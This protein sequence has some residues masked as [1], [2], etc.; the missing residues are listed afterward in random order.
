MGTQNDRV[1][2]LTE[3]LRRNI[4]VQ[5]NSIFGKTFFSK[6]LDTISLKELA[7]KLEVETAFL[8]RYAV[9]YRENLSKPI[10]ID[11]D[12][13]LQLFSIYNTIEGD[14][15][16]LPV[17]E[18]NVSAIRGYGRSGILRNPRLPIRESNHLV[19]LIVHMIGDG[20]LTEEYGT[21][22]CPQYSNRNAFLRNQF[23]YTISEVFGDVSNCIRCYI[24]RSNE[25][26]SYIAFSKWIGYLLRY[27]YPDARFDE[28]SGSLPSAFFT[29][30][31]ELK[32]EIVRTFGDDDGHVGAHGI[33]FTSGG[34]TI[35]EQMRELIVEL[36]EVTLAPDECAQL[37]VS[38]GEVKAVRSY[39]ILDV[40]RPM[41]AW[42][43]EYI[44]F[45]H[46]DR[47]ERL[48]FQ[49][50]CDRVWVERGLDGFDLDFLTLMELRAGG[51]VEEIARRFMV[52]EDF[53]FKVVQ[54]LREWKWIRRVEKRQYTTW[55]Q[56][57]S[58][59][60]AF[61]ERIWSR[62]WS[63]GDRVVMA[64]GWWS[65]LRRLL[66]AQFKTAAAV[67]RAAGM[68][69]T[70]TRRYLQGRRQWMDAKWV[71]ALAKL[72]G[73]GREKVSQGLVVG[74]GRRL[75]PR[76]EQCDFLA[77]QLGVY[78][79]FS[80]GEIGFKDWL[81]THRGRMVRSERLL[82]AGFAEKLQTA[83]VIRNRII[84]LAVAGGGEVTLMELKSDGV[85]QGLVAN[86]YP[87][88]LADRMAKLIKQ[89]VFVRVLKGRYQLINSVER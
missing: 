41:Y 55:Y 40:Y 45:T 30:P 11:L 85:L 56:T 38:V 67:A 52:R 31:L 19:R 43:A 44:G 48:R 81:A 87:A 14:L 7:E 22:K 88:Y 54:R 35:L 28:V 12:I 20:S 86:R 70:T 76:Y 36:M 18:K 80:Q 24:D 71:V 49:L 61:L 37:M 62:G 60:E 5:L 73:W 42:Y 79:R 10:F 69:E 34:A 33:R 4:Y 51:S 64:E 53:V 58:R 75:A 13:L 83:S 25:S 9:N 84:E 63:V 23:L 17:L 89:D 39:F 50:E 29:L 6:I 46:P 21:S 26:R 68:P 2:H 1:F 57:T 27:W 82:D 3:F 32:A 65:E 74:V 16:V 47:A 72:V 15:D 77:K 59:G 8:A 78:W 66:L